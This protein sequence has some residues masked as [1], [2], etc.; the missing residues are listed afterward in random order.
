MARAV[1]SISG[2]DCCCTRNR[3]RRGAGKAAKACGTA[4]DRIRAPWL[5]PVTSTWIGPRAFGAA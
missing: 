3:L 1:S 2:R 5:P 4:S